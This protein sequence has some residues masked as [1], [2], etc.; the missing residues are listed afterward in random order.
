MRFLP[1]YSQMPAS[2]SSAR[3]AHCLRHLLHQTE[4]RLAAGTRQPL[5]EKHRHGGQNHAAI[6]VMLN[7]L[8]RGI[9][10]ADGSV[11]FKAFEVAARSIR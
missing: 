8:H 10:D 3:L 6:G 11:T 1:R 9:A 5:V 4:Q 7:L 2:G